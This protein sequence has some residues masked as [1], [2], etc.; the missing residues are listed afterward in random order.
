VS[1]DVSRRLMDSVDPHMITKAES[2]AAQVTGV[3]HA[4]ARARWTGRTLRLEVEG[5]VDASTSVADA[6]DIGGAVAEWIAHDTP[7]ARSFTWTARPV[8]S[9]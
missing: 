4:H 9:G 6:D 7:E 2:V 5:W 8:A 3:R 1:A